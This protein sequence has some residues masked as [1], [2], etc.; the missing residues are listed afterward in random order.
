MMLRGLAKT[1]LKKLMSVTIIYG[2]LVTNLSLV[3]EAIV[4]FYT[5]E[6]SNLN[7]SLPLQTNFLD[8][9]ELLEKQLQ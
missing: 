4:Y 2:S 8:L 6:L 7:F 1:L 9:C 3:N 5:E